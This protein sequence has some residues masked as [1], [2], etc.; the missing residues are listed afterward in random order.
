M[1]GS[2]KTGL[3]IGL[4]EEAAIDGIP[5]IAIDPKGDLGNL[6]LSFPQLR[7]EDFLPWVD[8]DEAGRRGLT[9][10]QFAARTSEQWKEG[11]SAWGEDGTGLPVTQ[12][13]RSRDLYT[14]KY[15]RAAADGAPLVRC[16]TAG[17]GQPDRSL[18]RADCV[19]CFGLLA[20]SGHHG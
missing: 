13:G 11:L 9:V 6:L 2:G 12:R 17:L 4:L 14:G 15:C 8:A 10:E 16:T 1:T 20:D 3:G 19:G 7:P 5:V 18:S